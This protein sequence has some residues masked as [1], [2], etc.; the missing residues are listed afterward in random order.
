MASIDTSTNQVCEYDFVEQPHEIFFCPVLFDVL[1]EPYQMLCCGNHLSLEAYQRLRG[2]PCPVCRQENLAAVKD[3][4]HKR[5][6]MSQLV[7]CPNKEEGCEWEGELGNLEQH[8][9][10][11]GQCQ[12]T[13]ID[14]PY[15]CGERAQRREL[16]EHKSHHC[17]LRPFTC[18]YCNHKA[19]HQE[20]TEDHWPVCQKYPLPCP[21]EC[22]QEIERQSLEEHQEQ[23]CPLESIECEFL[24]AGCNAVLQRHLMP[25]HMEEGMAAHLSMLAWVGRQQAVLIERQAK[26]INTLMKMQLRMVENNIVPVDF[27][28]HFDDEVWHSSPFYS[29]VG[30]YKMRLCG[31]TNGQGEYAD[32]THVSVFVNLMRGE[33]DDLLKW[34]FSGDVITEVVS[35]VQTKSSS[36]LQR[37]FP[38]DHDHDTAD[39][40]VCKPTQESSSRG[41]GIPRYISH[42]NLHTG[43]YLKDN[44]YLIRVNKVVVK[45]K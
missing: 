5:T 23:T 9:S 35:Q 29:H 14:C 21:N 42:D 30:G 15:V 34:P 20:V 36:N 38:V 8:L 18:Q 37:I 3:K 24:Y 31:Y 41:F 25:A 7:R 2:K 44:K 11:A 39:E 28:I 17:P 33:F 27:T 1:V 13:W 6:V 26:Q 22:G 40:G 19:T 32:G 12:Y 4:F 43:G 45:S 16:E 10:Y